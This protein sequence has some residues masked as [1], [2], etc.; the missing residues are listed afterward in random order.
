VAGR[1][2]LAIAKTG[3]GKTL[4]FLLPVLTR[5]F[6]KNEKKE[7]KDN[8]KEGKKKN[9]GEGGGVVRG[10]RGLVMAPTRELALQVNNIKCIIDLNYIRYILKI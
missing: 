6:L 5:C 4:G 7:K 2:V 9:G 8:L 1:D 10:P 3:S